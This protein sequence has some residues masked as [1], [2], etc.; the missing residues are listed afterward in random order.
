MSVAR[1]LCV[2]SSFHHNG[3]VAHTIHKLCMCDA[4][5][6]YEMCVLCISS[7]PHDKNKQN[8]GFS[9]EKHTNHSASK[10]SNSRLTKETSPN[11][12]E[13]QANGEQQRQNKI[14]NKY[15]SQSILL[16]TVNFYLKMN[17]LSFFHFEAV[18]CCCW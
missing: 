10:K 14:L 1:L 8:F 13:Q 18:F 11:E 9:S 5:I 16:I 7:K 6:F 17:I 4:L 15:F 3:M 12:H 2:P